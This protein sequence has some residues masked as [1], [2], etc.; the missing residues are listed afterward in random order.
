[1]KKLYLLLV[2]LNNLAITLVLT[3]YSI[4]L[5]NNIIL[6]II[7]FVLYLF[8]TIKIIQRKKAMEL[9]DLITLSIYMLF[10]IIYFI[11]SIVYQIH[12]TSTFSMLYFSQ[13]IIIPN[14]LFN[15]F[16]LFK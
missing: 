3:N 16:N 9:I 2:I 12:N 13:F 10:L 7:I 14:I 1:M 6:P 15:L 4:T 8:I 5:W 11:F